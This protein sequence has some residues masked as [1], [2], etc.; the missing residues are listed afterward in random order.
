MRKLQVLDILLEYRID[1][2]GQKRLKTGKEFDRKLTKYKYLQ[3]EK[4]THGDY[5]VEYHPFEAQ[6]TQ[7]ELSKKIDKLEQI[8]TDS[9]VRVGDALDKFKII[10]TAHGSEN[11]EFFST[12]IHSQ[13][14]CRFKHPHPE[15]CETADKYLS[16]VKMA[17]WLYMH[18]LRH[19]ENDQW[20]L[21]IMLNVCHAATSSAKKIGDKL[22]ESGLTKFFV[23]ASPELLTQMKSGKFQAFL[24]P[25]RGRTARNMDIFEPYL[26]SWSED[27]DK[28]IFHWGND[29]C[30][31]KRTATGD[32]EVFSEIHSAWQ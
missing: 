29:G 20:K 16:S 8:I 5:E 27:G 7:V 22:Y 30:K 2:D 31:I 1:V 9:M 25:Q 32:Y 24:R 13:R 10:I 26:Y 3:S 11:Q 12:S 4:Y 6:V 28:V 19:K 14:K 18:G 23:T 21:V 17:Q 15:S